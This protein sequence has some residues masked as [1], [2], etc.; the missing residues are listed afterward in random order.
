MCSFIGGISIE[1]C[2]GFGAARGHNLSLCP[3]GSKG[4]GD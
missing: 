1:V 2:R 4:R 3:G